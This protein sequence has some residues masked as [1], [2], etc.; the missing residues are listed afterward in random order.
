MKNNEC[1]FK[2]EY[3]FS[4]VKGTGWG[5]GGVGGGVKGYHLECEK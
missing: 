2:C 4:L 3:R 1:K 5:E